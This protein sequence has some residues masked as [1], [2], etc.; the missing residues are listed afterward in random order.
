MSVAICDQ[1]AFYPLRNLVQ[2]PLAS[3][4]DLAD[5]E[6]FVRTVVLHDEISME[7]EP[8]PYDPDSDSEFTEEEKLAGGRNVVVAI[9]PTLI[10]YDFFM[11]KNSGWK[12]EN[13]N[14]A[15]SPALLE[16]ARNFSNAD[17]G[18]V[19]YK[20]HIEHLQHIVSTIKKGGSAL[21]AGQFGSAAIDAS[22]KYP[23]K[24][25]ENLDQDWQQFA[26]EVDAGKLD[27]M[28]PP[29]LSII[30]SRCA[31]RDAIPT[32]LKDLRDEWADARIKVWALLGQLKTA[33]TI[34]ETRN[35]REELAAASILMS[36]TQNEFDTKPIRVLWDLIA[37]SVTGAFIALTSGSDPSDGAVTG[38]L[39]MASRSVPPLINELGPVM[40][41]RGAFDLAKRVRKESLRVEYGALARLLTTAEKHKLGF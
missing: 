34:S 37:G 4:N 3:V 11:E 22:T 9:G 27:I 5:V 41:G 1:K 19:Y 24:L 20:A 26:R 12:P 14:L 28:V 40:F 29:V 36:P 15:L 23:E 2:G 32:I 31:R 13:S 38:A 7:N 33:D 21:L 10:G 30:L 39:S 16:I 18:N 35:I 25:F 6:R 17:E 8:W